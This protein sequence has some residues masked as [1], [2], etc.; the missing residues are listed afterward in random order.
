MLVVDR[1]AAHACI[2]ISLE[3]HLSIL[4]IVAMTQKRQREQIEP[5]EW[6]WRGRMLTRPA[7]GRSAHSTRR[8]RSTEQSQPGSASF[9]TET[10]G[11]QISNA[12][13]DC[14]MTRTCA[15]PTLFAGRVRLP[16]T[17]SL[18]EEGAP[19]TMK[20]QMSISLCL[21]RC[22][23]NTALIAALEAYSQARSPPQ[24]IPFQSTPRSTSSHQ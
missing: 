14:C 8:S 7:P 11:P 20:L 3:S 5:A 21:H 24:S 22:G 10:C 18:L 1:L 4:C 13:H 23:N 16:V 9:D 12:D 15:P 6:G 19:P 17:S 2:Q